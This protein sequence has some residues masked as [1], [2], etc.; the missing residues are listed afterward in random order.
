MVLVFFPA[1]QWAYK[2]ASPPG[3]LKGVHQVGSGWGAW[4]FYNEATSWLTNIE[5]T[6]FETY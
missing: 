4:E 5:T 6:H 3:G 2:K 1:G